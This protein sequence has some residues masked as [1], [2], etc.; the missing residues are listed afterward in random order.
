MTIEGFYRDG[1]PAGQVSAELFDKRG[2]LDNEVT[3]PTTCGRCG[4]AG[5]ADKWAATGWTCFDCG[6]AGKVVKT[7][8]KPIYTAERLA[9]LNAAEAKRRAT[10]IA[11]AEAARLAAE[12]EAEAFR[13]RNAEWL[14]GARPYAARSDFIADVLRR[15]E[16]SGQLTDRQREAVDAAVTKIQARDAEHAA[17]VAA[18]AFVGQVGE[19]IR[20]TATVERAHFLGFGDYYPPTPRFVITLRDQLNRA[21]TYFGAPTWLDYSVDDDHAEAKVGYQ[22][23][24]AAT[25]KEH[26]TYRGEKQTSIARP[27]EIKAHGLTSR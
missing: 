18:S 15:V 13:Q 26:R 11:K 12:A 16:S 1:T 10:A 22:V 6:G 3:E 19:R 24:L 5:G 2:K 7:F 27:K 21:L 17:N 25:V 8:R 4:G 20:F 23:T 14:A 9:R